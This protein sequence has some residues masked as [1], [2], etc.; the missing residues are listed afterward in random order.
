MPLPEPYPLPKHFKSNIEQDLKNG[1]MS[2]NSRRVFLSDVASSML[3]YKKYPTRDDYANVA[4]SIIKDYPFLKAP[5]GAGT[6]HV[7]TKQY[8]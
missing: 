2:L 1:K 3:A 4:R 5:L 6:P 7:R 8:S